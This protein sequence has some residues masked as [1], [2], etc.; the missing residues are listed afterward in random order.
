MRFL[1]GGYTADMDGAASGIGMLTAG[2]AD[3]PLA[4]GQLGFA[5]SIVEAPSPSWVA[6]HPSLDVFYAALEGTGAVQAFRRTGDESFVRLGPAVPVGELVCHVAIAPNAGSL[7]A[8]CWGDGHLVRMRLDAEGRPSSPTV[9]PAAEDPYGADAGAPVPEGPPDL[10]LAAAARALREAAGEEYAHLIPAH[11]AP[12]AAAEDE[13]DEADA[14]RV[15]R[16][17]QAR[18]LDGGLVATTDLGFDV[19][20][21]WRAGVAGMKLVQRVALPRGSGPRHTVWHPSGHLYV[22]CEHSCEVF[23]LAA[24]R[25]GVWRIVAGTAL[26]PGMLAGDA[27]AELAASRDGA[28]L[29]AG[30][31]GSDTIATVRVRGDGSQLEPIALV[32]A[33]AG[34]PR[35]HV[36]VRDTLLV[37]GQ[38]SH[39][40]VSL[41]LDARTGVPGRVRHRVAVPS[42]TC[43]TP[44]VGR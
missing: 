29:Y 31:R 25:E 3:S 23:A 11:D 4:G 5:E 37:A 33:G 20:R 17:H 24:D 2:E 9:A 8:S 44:D 10:D 16:A 41:A 12:A 35:H 40:V 1:V 27:A 14:V 36:V 13:P 34:W 21:I 19:V 32:E 28:F 38:L 42:P 15:S 7:L 6:A 22:V 39:E 30:L 18:F 26:S 43:L